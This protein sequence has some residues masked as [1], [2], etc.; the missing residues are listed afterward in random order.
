MQL[1]S[2]QPVRRDTCV[3]RLL[4]AGSPACLIHLPFGGVNVDPVMPASH[5]CPHHYGVALGALH[6]DGAFGISVS[7]GNLPAIWTVP[8]ER[9]PHVVFLH[10]PS[11]PS[12][13]YHFGQV[14]LFA[15]RLFIQRALLSPLES[16]GIRVTRWQRSHSILLPVS[17]K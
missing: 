17:S 4:Q 15:T 6:L 8:R 10:S 3:F 5:D 7:N 13:V 9:L 2:S 11:L 12:Q 1:V 16:A 14:E